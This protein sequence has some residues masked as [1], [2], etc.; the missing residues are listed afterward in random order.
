MDTLTLT[1]DAPAHLLPS[2]TRG[3]HHLYLDAPM[4]WRPYKRL[5]N[6]LA[7]A[8]I[9]D[10]KWAAASIKGG[11]SLL[12]PPGTAYNEWADP[13]LVYALNPAHVDIHNRH[14][15]VRREEREE[16][17][18]YVIE[19]YTALVP[20]TDRTR[21]DYVTSRLRDNRRLHAPALDIDAP[22]TL[23]PDPDVPGRAHLTLPGHTLTPRQHR[24]LAKMLTKAGISR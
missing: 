8:G 17:D 15:A 19:R 9:V 3:H 14:I 4:G 6:A 7:E 11:Q 1:F 21:A 10:P 20:T 12:R 23:V 5:L 24:R 16:R 13:A 22:A 2:R 18:G